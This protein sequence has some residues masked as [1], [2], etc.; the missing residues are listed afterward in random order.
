MASTSAAVLDGRSILSNVVS[1]QD[2]VHAE[3]GGVVP[4]LASRAHQENIVPVVHEALRQA[5]LPVQVG[6]I[7]L[8]A[9]LRVVAPNVLDL[10]A[11]PEPSAAVLMFLAA[12]FLVARRRR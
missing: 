7:A 12:S 8:F 9:S 1:S 2:D 5:G 3:Y 6:A 10:T 11:V 4:E